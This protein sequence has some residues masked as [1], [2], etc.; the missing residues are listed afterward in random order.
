LPDGSEAPTFHEIRSLA[1]REYLK[2]GGVDTLALLGHTDEKMG[3]LY[4]DNRGVEPVTVA[5][6]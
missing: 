3:A 5:V 1:K 6:D 4:A 2:Q